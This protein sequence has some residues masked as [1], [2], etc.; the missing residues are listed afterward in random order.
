M[1]LLD[2]NIFIRFVIPDD[3]GRAARCAKLFDSIST[4]RERALVTPTALAEVAWVL[5]GSYQLP[6]SN[7]IAALRRILHTE[8]LEIVDREI[9]IQGVDLFENHPIDFIDAY[10]AAF[11]A[12]REIPTIYSYDTDFDQLAGAGITRKEP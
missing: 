10:H 11:M 12:S 4:G 2:T 8:K 3:P 9:L 1:T 7:V 6:K 5:L